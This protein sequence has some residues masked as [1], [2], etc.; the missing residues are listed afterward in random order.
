MIT[1]VS[2]PTTRG[3]S[4]TKIRA[5]CGLVSTAITTPPTT[6]SGARTIM[7]SDIDAQL[8][9]LRDVVG[10]ACDE[11][12][13]VEHVEIGEGEGLDLGI[14]GVAHI[15]AHPLRSERGE[16]RAADA[17]DHA[18]HG[19]SDHDGAG[20]Q[21]EVQIAG[22]DAVV[23]DALHQPRLQKV[24]RDFEDHE[25]RSEKSPTPVGAQVLPEF[26]CGLHNERRSRLI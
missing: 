26:S 21:H 19:H 3:I 15:G 20:A 9:H 23:D 10:Q 5:S 17:A 18:D 16:D 6:S 22:G 8:L 2:M 1:N 7:R 25:Q 4:T 11:S 14:E 24:H 13:G 12:A